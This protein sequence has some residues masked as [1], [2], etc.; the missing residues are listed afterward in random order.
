MNDYSGNT[1]TNRILEQNGDITDQ[2]L[3]NNG[4]VRG[5]KVI[6]NYKQDMM[7]TGYNESVVRN[8]EDQRELEY[9]YTPFHGFNVISAI[10]TDSAG[11]IRGT[12][13]L[14]ESRAGGSSTIG[15]EDKT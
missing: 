14:S 13:V 10:F 6:G 8:G 5:Q 1:H 4:H 12:Q 3:D 7:F 9:H 15:R 2:F 11:D